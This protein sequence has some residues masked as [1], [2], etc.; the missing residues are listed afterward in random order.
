[1][2]HYQNVPNMTNSNSMKLLFWL[3][4]SASKTK[5]V[6]TVMTR[7]TFNGQKNFSSGISIDPKLWKSSSEKLYTTNAISNEINE[8]LDIIEVKLRQAYHSLK[9]EGQ[10]FDASMIYDKYANKKKF[11]YKVTDIS[12]IYES[13]KQREFNENHIVRATLKRHVR[14]SRQL[15]S[16]LESNGYKY[17]R[18]FDKFVFEQYIH[19]LR[20]TKKYKSSYINKQLDVIRG[21]NSIIK[22]QIILP[23]DLCKNISDLKESKPDTTHLIEKEIDAINSLKLSK[24]FSEFRDMLLFMIESGLHYADYLT[25]INNEIH[26]DENYNDQWIFIER[27]KSESEVEIMVTEKMSHLIDKYGGLKNLPAQSLTKYND[28]LKVIAQLAGITKNI[29]SKIG[30]KTFTDLH[31]NKKQT[32]PQ[33]IATML[34]HSSTKYIKHYANVKRETIRQV[35]AVIKQSA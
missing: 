25:A 9:S 18:K 22:E 20:F 10:A 31:L 2:L 8:E 5:K 14:I 21:W 19:H 33:F 17:F 1:M 26:I 15:V 7:I 13:L 24:R 6:A 16:Y 30:R 11:D 27:V 34:G 32:P 28:G 4:K 3:R 35:N 29:S 23:F 12:E